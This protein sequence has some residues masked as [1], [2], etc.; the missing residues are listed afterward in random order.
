MWPPSRVD[1]AGSANGHHTFEG[2]TPGPVCPAARIWSANR[3]RSPSAIG[4]A[5]RSAAPPATRTILNLRSL[6]HA[7]AGTTASHAHCFVA[8]ARPSINPASIGRLGAAMMP[9]TA[10]AAAR[11]S[12]GWP[13]VRALKVSGPAMIRPTTSARTVQGRPPDP[14]RTTARPR[15]PRASTQGNTPSRYSSSRLPPPREARA[16]NGALS[17]SEKLPIIGCCAKNP[18]RFP[19][20]RASIEGLAASLPIQDGPG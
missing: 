18:C 14:I 5:H 1:P 12:S 20:T 4:S 10:S 13:Q 15:T 9:P 3:C 17:T 2:V 16:A 6:A 11:S 7:T 8:I 19:A